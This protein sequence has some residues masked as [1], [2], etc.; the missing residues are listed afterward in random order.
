MD[1]FLTQLKVSGESEIKRVLN[2]D[3]HAVVITKEVNNGMINIGGR[4][5]VQVVY[6]SVDDE[7]E[8][9][10]GSVDF[11]EKQPTSYVLD[12][13]YV[14]DKTTVINVN[15]SGKDAICSVEHQA[16]VSGTYSYELGGGYDDESLVLNKKNFSCL[17]LAKTGED[18]FV[19]AEEVES[20]MTGV[21]VLEADAK[22]MAVEVSASVDKIVIE[23]NIL[24]NLT[25]KDADGTYFK[26]RNF[27][28]KQ[29]VN[30]TGVTPNMTAKADVQVAKITVTPEAKN[31][32]T[33]FVFA[34]DLNAKAI[35]YEE[36]NYDIVTDMFSLKNLITTT[37]DYVEMKS[38][39]ETK[40]V[41]ENVVSATNVADIEKF[42]DIVGIFNP[43]YECLG[44]ENEETKAQVNGNI[45]ATALY[46]ADGQ[47]FK[48]D[49][50]CPVQTTISK[51]P[52]EVASKGD[53]LVE[54]GTNKVKAGKELEVNFKLD[55]RVELEVAVSEKFIK[56]YEN[57]GERVAN[58]GGV[59]V[60]IAGEGDTLF[61]IAKAI[62]VRPETISKQNDE[63]TVF[64]KDDKIYV[65]S[66]I[67]LI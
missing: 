27:E 51:Q 1:K 56:G 66:P 33:N 30:A 36:T 6:V 20:N 23:G 64:E 65:Y 22:A 7:I 34:I 54:I 28:F 50:V 40:V 53:G 45:K 10:A 42:D 60:Y 39:A 37:T 8:T 55:I 49:I 24:A 41:T 31:D 18:N 13:I 14:E 38:Y 21:T 59:T 57:A 43:Y 32:K 48:L 25:V 4:I 11:I 9:M 46:L 47:I 67:N 58:A 63:N 26:Q 61:D 2:T 15:F 19:V 29:E 62:C 35:A 12:D 17:K 44:I 5:D 3:A 16:K 52:N